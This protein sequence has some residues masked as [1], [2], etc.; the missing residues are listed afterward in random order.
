MSKHMLHANMSRDLSELM[1]RKCD[2]SEPML[3]TNI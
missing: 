1:L 2:M 3:R